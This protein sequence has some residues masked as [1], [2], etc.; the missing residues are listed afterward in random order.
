M[1][2]LPALCRPQ[3]LGALGARRADAGKGGSAGH[4]HMV[5]LAGDGVGAAQLHR[6]QAPADRFGDLADRVS[7]QRVGGTLSAAL[8]VSH[9]RAAPSCRSRPGLTWRDGLAG[10]AGYASVVGGPRAFGCRWQRRVMSVARRPLA[11]DGSER[12]K[13]DARRGKVPS[14]EICQSVRWVIRGLKAPPARPDHCGRAFGAISAAGGLGC[15]P[16]TVGRSRAC[17][18]S[19]VASRAP[20]Q[21]HGGLGWRADDCP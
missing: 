8:A 11:A 20:A 19:T 13:E 15:Q 6:P 1:P 18:L 16:A 12:A 3:R 2:A 21:T 14:C 5:C 9:E 17:V 10:P 7:G 4:H